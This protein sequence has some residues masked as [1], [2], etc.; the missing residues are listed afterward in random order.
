MAS[1]SPSRP[2]SQSPT[3]PVAHSSPP[4]Q[5]SDRPSAHPPLFHPSSVRALLTQLNFQPSRVLGQ[6]F[7]IDGNILRILVDAADPTP[8][9]TVLE[10]GPG[11]GVL[12]EALLAR[13]GRVIAIEKDARLH[14]W[15]TQ[16]FAAEPR[17]DLRLGDALRA[18]LPALFAGGVNKLAANLPYSV[19]SRILMDCFMAARGPSRI[20]VT[21]QKEVADR[22]AAAPGGS[23]YGLLSVWAQ[24]RYHVRL[25]KVIPRTCFLPAPEVTSAIVTLDRKAEDP[26]PAELARGFADL[27]KRA[28]SQRRK[29]LGGLLKNPDACVAAGI[30]PSARPEELA[31]A[32]WIRLAAAL[33]NPPK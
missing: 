20:V 2:L 25:H 3:R 13:A 27:V 18:D 14:A 22:L 23:D 8:A 9:E 33:A 4:P 15:L 30:A 19:G 24:V 5:P 16:R 28:F 29:Q 26:L 32:D 12:T 11:L 17:L 10:I 6:N 21:V 1:P 7:L 31:V